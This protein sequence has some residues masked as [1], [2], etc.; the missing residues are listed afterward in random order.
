[1]IVLNS[2]WA[3]LTMLGACLLRA[4]LHVQSDNLAVPYSWP[5]TLQTA[6]PAASLPHLTLQPP[7]NTL[8]FR[9]GQTCT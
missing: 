3:Q 9:T 8:T 5:D 2:A 4:G 6:V 1:M 7:T